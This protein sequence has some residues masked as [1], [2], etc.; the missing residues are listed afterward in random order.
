MTRDG[1]VPVLSRSGSRPHRLSVAAYD[2]SMTLVDTRMVDLADETIRLDDYAGLVVVPNAGDETFAALRPDERSWRAITAHLADI[3]SPL[4][5]AVLWWT[6]IDLAMSRSS[7]LADLVTLVDRQLRPERHPVVFE[8][9][10]S[11]V[12]RTLRRYAEPDELADLLRRVSDVAQAAVESGD[13][14]LAPAASRALASTSTDQALLRDWLTK[15]GVDQEVRWLAVHRLASL[16][17]DSFL[18]AEEQRDRSV[19]GH[20]SALAARAAVP[21]SE[22]K[23]ASW[24]LLMSGTLSNHEYDA[25]A[26]GFWGWEQAGLLEPFVERYLADAVAL[27]RESGQ[28][29]GKVISH[30]F[31][32]L[33]LGEPIRR[34]LRA[35]LAEVLEGEV[36]TVL[37]RNWNDALDDLDRVLA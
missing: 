10:I 36:P 6:A 34:S 19:A 17:D 23:E 33:P 7:S 24:T 25:V 13:P 21:T 8:A 29:M 4:T 5:R 9:V 20:H 18:D 30:A 28:A 11:F 31:P 35:Q 16:G 15:D 2:D 12:L 1:D 32:W 3:E 14:G 37:A 22:A 27:A 26:S